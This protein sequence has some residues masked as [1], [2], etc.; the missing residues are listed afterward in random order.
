MHQ[1]WGKLLFIH[2]PIPAELLR[3]LIPNNLSI[4]TFDGT[5]WI[6]VVPFTMW[7]IRP[8]LLPPIPPWNAFHE[9]N[10]RTYVS[11]KGIPGVWF[12]SLDARSRLAVWGARTFFHLPYRY[13]EMTLDQVGDTI[14]YDSRRVERGY[15]NADLRAV[16]QIGD[17]L[18]KSE[19]GSLAYFLTERY[20][21]YSAKNQKLY[22]CRIL[23]PHWPL[24]K[25]QLAECNS[26]MIEAVGL[27]TPDQSPLLH[28][29]ETISVKIWPL[30]RIV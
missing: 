14:H 29:A 26:T 5:A 18:P 17:E 22:R 2:W 27:P 19:P 24:R 25:A 21:L 7:G 6:A 10:V 8:V 15:P 9:L 23:H 30:E 3:P 4:D 16:W 1:K 20:C 12:F 28:Y 11:Y 13:A